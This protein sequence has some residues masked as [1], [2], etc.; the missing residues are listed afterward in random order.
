MHPEFNQRASSMCI[1]NVHPQRASSTPI[2][3][4]PSIS[5]PRP[6]HP[7][8]FWTRGSASGWIGF[9]WL[10]GNSTDLNNT[11]KH[12][13]N[14]KHRKNELSQYI[15]FSKLV[16]VLNVLKHSIANVVTDVVVRCAMT[17][18]STSTK[19]VHRPHRPHRLTYQ[20][21]THTSFQTK[22][23]PIATSMECKC[24]LPT[25]PVVRCF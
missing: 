16:N 8:L 11:E 9:W 18:T 1:R 21:P 3:L 15:F 20:S 6:P 2:I 10:F 13:R 7:A 12:W 19:E 23:G 4:T 17:F 25:T 5:T 22:P 24:A 14:T